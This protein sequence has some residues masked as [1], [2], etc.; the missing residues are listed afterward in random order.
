MGWWAGNT[1]HAWNKGHS[2]MCESIRQTKYERLDA[3]EEPQVP[4][5]TTFSTSFGGPKCPP[6]SEVSINKDKF[7]FEK[8]PAYAAE[9]FP[10]N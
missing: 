6:I 2:S 3:R 1:F 9:V 4:A 5:T 10:I 8:Q 7:I